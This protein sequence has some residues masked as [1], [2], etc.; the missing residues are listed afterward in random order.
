MAD[1][2][3]DRRVMIAILLTS[4]LLTML[5]IGGIFMGG[6][7]LR[8]GPLPEDLRELFPGEQD[9]D[10]DDLMRQV[11]LFEAELSNP[12]RRP[13]AAANVVVSS[14]VLV[15]S[16]MLTWRRKLSQWWI[17]QAVV[18]KLIWIVG[19]TA[20]LVYHLKLVFPNLLAP[21]D[22]GITLVELISSVVLMSVTSATL[23]LLAAWRVSRPDIGDFLESSRKAS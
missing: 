23:H 17:R 5:G 4:T 22:E 1:E 9:P 19:Y 6:Y 3:N 2:S 11:Q 21:K 10:D 12:Y 15:G 14:L 20:T 7:G 16:F 18:A 13:M 8:T